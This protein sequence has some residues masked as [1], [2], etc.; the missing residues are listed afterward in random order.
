M[1]KK[2]RIAVSI[3]DINGIGVE[4]ALKA[5]QEITQICHPIYCISQTMLQQAAQL[6]NTQ[7]P[8]N[9]T[10]CELT[11]SFT[12]QPG[13]V[14]AASGRYAYDSFMQGVALCEQN[15]AD[16]VVTMPIHKEAWMAAN[17]PYKGHTDLLRQHFHKD[18]IMM[19]GCPQMYVALYT[20]HIPLSQVPHTIQHARLVRFFHDFH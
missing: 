17:L 16:A 15:K 8:H 10:L 2:P 4:I 7:L 6:L 12:I 20:E 19:L 18:A 13:V 5:H 14:D 3:G 9:I 11:S 1:T